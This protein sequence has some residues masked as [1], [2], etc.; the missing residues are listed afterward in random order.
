VKP[1]REWRVGRM[2]SVRQL[3]AD[4]GVTP[5]TLIDLELGRRTAQYGTMRQIAEA[6]GV[7]ANEISEF[8]LALKRRAGNTN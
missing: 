2:Q 7:P 1:L 6:I 3:A 5:K 4:A 8:A